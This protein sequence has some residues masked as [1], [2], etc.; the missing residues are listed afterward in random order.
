MRACDLNLLTL[1]PALIFSFHK[2]D[3]ALRQP[4]MCGLF[5]GLL[6]VRRSLAPKAKTMIEQRA[7]FMH[8]KPPKD[9]VGPVVSFFF[10]PQK[11]LTVHQLIFKSVG[12]EMSWLT[13]MMELVQ[14][15]TVLVLTVF[16]VAILGPSGWILSHLDH[17][18]S[19]G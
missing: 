11:T 17:Y 6:K 10:L 14:Q 7:G 8:S 1:V 2:K 18:K 16:S 3:F 19:R 12:L 5:V 13:K 15:Q 4:N 9:R